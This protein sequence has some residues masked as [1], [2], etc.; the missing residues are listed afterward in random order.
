[1]PDFPT[2]QI[3]EG[4]AHDALRGHL[5]ALYIHAVSS[6]IPT[7]QV[8]GWYLRKHKKIKGG[9]RTFLSASLFSLL[10]KRVRTS[11]VRCFAAL[12]D[13]VEYNSKELFPN[14]DVHGEALAAIY[15]WLREDLGAEMPAAL[16]LTS[17]AWTVA[18][19][20]FLPPEKTPGDSAIPLEDLRDFAHR[21][22]QDSALV[23]RPVSI[24]DAAT[25]SIPPEILDRWRTRFPGEIYRG[26][27]E[28]ISS[29]APLIIR[30]N[31]LKRSREELLALLREQE[32]PAKPAAFA[33]N[34]ILLERKVNLK[35]VTDLEETDYEIQDEG[36]QLV[37]EAL[38]P[39]APGMKI[40]DAC[41]GA[42]GK[43]L[44]LAAIVN[45]A[46]DIFAFDID[47]E[48][49]ARLPERQKKIGATSI[50]LLNHETLH[51][52]APYDAVLIDAP[53]LGF[54]RLRREPSVAWRGDLQERLEDIS[55]QQRDCLRIY[56]E[57]LKPGGTLVYATCSFEPEETTEVLKKSEDLSPN[58]VP[59]IFQ[60]NEF[61]PTRSEDGSS[62]VLLPSLHGTDGFFIGRM[63]KKEGAD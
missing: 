6:E 37:S 25:Y 20:G 47:Q 10:R 5:L 3:P 51:E 46:A 7:Q 62:V 17:E 63:R 59:K 8:V 1:M 41:A 38:G 48:R 31:T 33:A 21:F 19:S 15:R 53:C 60:R 23:N 28:S 42:G 12:P 54:G 30:A 24:Q 26:L 44:H 45:N 9:A 43:A 11:L 56:T 49:L 18:T 35:H 2:R 57:L 40:L 27:C 39:I 4:E 52:N 22:E 32:L 16:R 13:R 55:A 50:K 34:G 29:T 61:P 58:P 14:G 36:S